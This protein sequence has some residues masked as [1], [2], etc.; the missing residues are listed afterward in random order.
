MFVFGLSKYTLE[1]L[2]KLELDKRSLGKETFIM[3]LTTQFLAVGATRGSNFSSFLFKKKKKSWLIVE[4][5]SD[6]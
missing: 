4:H 6:R 2:G 5:V 3:T 1:H